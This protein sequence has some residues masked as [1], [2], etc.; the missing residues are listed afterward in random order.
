MAICN[1]KPSH[2]VLTLKQAMNAAYKNK[3]FIY[4]SYFA[5][6]LIRVVETNPNAAKPDA[7]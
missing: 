3:N 7:V 5:K 4:C 1:L 2:R 6:K